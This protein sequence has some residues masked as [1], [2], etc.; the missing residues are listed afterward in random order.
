MFELFTKYKSALFALSGAAL[1][2]AFAIVF[3]GPA[4]WRI[5]AGAIA[6]TV[7]I[8]LPRI[9][10]LADRPENWVNAHLALTTAGRALRILVQAPAVI[11]PFLIYC[12]VGH[13]VFPGEVLGL[14]VALA[15]LALLLSAQGFEAI[16]ISL[17]FRGTGD[18]LNNILLGLAI[19]SGVGALVA[20]EVPG[21]QAALF[22]GVAIFFMHFLNGIASDIR[23]RIAPHRGVGIFF[24]TFN[25]IHNSHLGN[26]RRALDERGL[27]KVYMHLT[28][29]PK[30]HARALAAG[31]IVIAKQEAGMRIYE[32]TATAN[33]WK[34]YF[35]TGNRFYE[36]DVRLA[37]A[38]AAL[39]DVGLA[40]RVE[41]LDLPDLYDR[42]GFYGVLGY[43]K[44]LHPGAAIHGIHGSDSGGMWLRNIYEESGWIYPFPVIRK[45]N[46]SATAIRQGAK[47]MTTRVVEE[48]IEDLRAGTY[49]VSK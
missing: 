8:A 48:A 31:E 16:G 42:K 47:G 27:E 38:R 17:Y 35:P 1:P 2:I 13:D 3:P 28:L 49:R 33:R 34:N 12:R 32:K 5:A 21:G 40:D 6:I 9:V 10:R 45:D 20:W 11:V 39:Q 14:G 46:I 26:V 37:L 25:P 43:V 29:V 18:R 41:V 36:Y 24:G 15:A 7:A 19:G 30:L 23:S 4:A 44:K 22:L